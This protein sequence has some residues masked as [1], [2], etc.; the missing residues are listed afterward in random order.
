[1]NLTPNELFGHLR[2]VLHQPASAY[3]WARV[4][5]LLDAAREP[6]LS[7]EL[8]PYVNTHMRGWPDRL[9]RLPRHWCN[10]LNMGQDVPQLALVKQIDL[11]R[12]FG[13]PSV[14]EP[15]QQAIQ[16]GV[17]EPTRVSL[18]EP[19]EIEHVRTLL[20]NM[21]H[22]PL[23]HLEAPGLESIAGESMALDEFMNFERL[24]S[25]SLLDAW[26]D[27]EELLDVLSNL[28]HLD[29][30]KEIGLTIRPQGSMR[31]LW[32]LLLQTSQLRTRL[33]SITLQADPRS[34]ATG[35]SL[36]WEAIESHGLFFDEP[37]P[38]LESLT[39]RQVEFPSSLS[40]TA[41]AFKLP[42]LRCI[43]FESCIID[44]EG[45]RGVLWM[46]GAS[47][48]VRLEFNHC[49]LS[50]QALELIAS[51]DA[52]R[53]RLEHLSLA[54]NV[55]G[56]DVDALR[57]VFGDVKWPKLRTLNLG[58]VEIRCASHEPLETHEGEPMFPVLDKLV[59][60]SARISEPAYYAL[61]RSELPSLRTLFCANMDITG[62][63]DPQRAHMRSLRQ[64]T[65]APWF[66]RLRALDLPKLQWTADMFE[67]IAGARMPAL[68]ELYG[69][70]DLSLNMGHIAHASWLG[71]LDVLK[72]EISRPPWYDGRIAPHY[73]EL[74]H[75]S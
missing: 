35:S 70:L 15:L 56:F 10:R 21:H 58:F 31:S 38:V 68:R 57:D 51:H 41:Q 12:I 18:H 8:I 42:A 62:L 71:H 22:L 11:S 20:R 25:L 53:Q 60:G 24:E 9:R 26:S 29:T 55:M 49:Y 27:D 66:E 43:K 69:A 28:Q 7:E 40:S 75:R 33:E 59:L 48:I 44:M 52:L 23:T 30:L 46:L 67:H 4:C 74:V 63:D 5:T 64:M 37:W 61:T 6:E 50:E 19:V 72:P 34:E 36:L 39:F 16:E 47:P 1:M 73:H 65:T 14:M 45:L 3:T 13:K 54:S 2:S 32:A 17:L